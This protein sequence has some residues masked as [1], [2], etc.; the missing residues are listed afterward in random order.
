LVSDVGYRY[1][2]GF[3]WYADFLDGKPVSHFFWMMPRK[4]C[5]TPGTPNTDTSVQGVPLNAV[6]IQTGLF[7]FI[8][9]R[10][11]GHSAA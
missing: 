5:P 7:S 4:K 2:A 11:N 10:A 6:A 8:R 9:L 1:S 3:A